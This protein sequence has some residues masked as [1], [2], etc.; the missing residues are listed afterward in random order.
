MRGNRTTKGNASGLAGF[1]SANFRPL[2]D[3]GVDYKVDWHRV[4]PPPE[5]PFRVCDS[6]EGHVAI[7]R[8]FPG[9]KEDEL[10]NV[11][12]PPLKGLVLQ[13]FGAGNAPDNAVPILQEATKRGVIVVNVTQCQKGTVEAHYAVGV[14]L[15]R[16]GVLPGY[17]MTVEAALT[18]LGHLLG[19]GVPKET[20]MEMLEQDLRGELT[21]PEK[22]GARFSFTDNTFISSVYSALHKGAKAVG[23]RAEGEMAFIVQALNPV[24]MCSA[25]GE[26]NLQLLQEMVGNGADVNAADYDDRTPLHVA[27][28]EGHL[29]VCKLLVQSGSYVNIKDKHGHSPLFEAVNNGH[30]EVAEFL[31]QS[32]GVLQLKQYRSATLLLNAATEGEAEVV[33]RWCRFGVS[34]S[35][36]DYDRRTAGHIAACEGHGEV[37]KVLKKHGALFDVKDRWGSTAI[38]EA[39]KHH[40]NLL[41]LMS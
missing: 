1:I 12:R 23:A 39:T 9:F 24:L 20:V 34:V 22:A 37:L 35:V 8:L 19:L 2:I 29:E 15:R 25:A 30:I 36:S 28:S 5:G 26:G 3:L 32:Q 40:P 41:S 17:D 21:L 6:Y 18:K 14:A 31:V 7:F 38:D 27:A 4:L 10:R 16:V 11:L 13:T 33:D